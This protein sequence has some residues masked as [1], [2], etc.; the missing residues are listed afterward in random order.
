MV[1]HSSRRFSKKHGQDMQP[2]ALIKAEIVK[3]KKNDR[4][5]CAVAFEIAKEMNIFPKKV[6]EIADLVNCK[7]AK[8]QLGLFGY[9]RKINLAKSRDL[10]KLSQNMELKDAVLDALVNGKLACK[11]AWKIASEFNV[12]KFS[13]AAL[14]N[15]MEIGI[16]ECQ[17]GIF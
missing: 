9:K 14:C 7:L 2:D 4:L 6:G 15:L 3:R 11:C 8:C 13:L 10:R 5:P 17:L 12:S 1:T 16:T